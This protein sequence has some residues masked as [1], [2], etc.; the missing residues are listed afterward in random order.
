MEITQD[1]RVADIKFITPMSNL[2][3]GLGGVVGTTMYFAGMKNDLVNKKIP[4]PDNKIKQYIL[5]ILE[6]EYNLKTLPRKHRGIS[7]PKKDEGKV[8]N[9]LSEYTDADLVLDV[10]SKI[11]ANYVPF[12]MSE[13]KITYITS[14]R[15]IDRQTNSVVFDDAC[16]YDEG[17]YSGEPGHTRDDLTR[18]PEVLS[19]ILNKVYDDCVESMR[20]SFNKK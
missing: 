17:L 19:P 5:S 7:G 6:K 16:F 4:N 12:K 9:I 18:K 11:E 3:N 8:K 2:G 13:Y 14:I 1:S 15:I 10:F 20:K